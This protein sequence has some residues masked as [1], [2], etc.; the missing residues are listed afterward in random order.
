MIVRSV[1]PDSPNHPVVMKIHY[2]VRL[3]EKLP[4]MRSE[5]K[6]MSSL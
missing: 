5:N 6:Y 1:T 2:F 3:E 4:N